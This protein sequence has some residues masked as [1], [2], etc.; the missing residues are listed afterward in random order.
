MNE[1]LLKRSEVPVELTWDLTD[2]Y[3]DNAE[4][5]ERMDWI[6]AE[7]KRFAE[8]WQGKLNTAE[9]IVQAMEQYR[10]VYEEMTLAGNYAELA[11]VVDYTDGELQATVGK[12][13]R[14][15]ADSASRLSF[16]DSELAQ[17]EES[18]L[19]VAMEQTTTAKHYLEEVIRRKPHLLHPEAERVLEA[20]APTAGMAFDIYNTAKLA[21]LQFSPFEVDG[22][23]YPL[24][25]AMFEDDY[26]YDENTA[27]R[28]AAFEAFSEQS[29]AYQNTI[30]TAYNGQIQ[31]E[32]TIA[33]L[34]GFDSVID[35]LLFEQ[36]VDRNLYERQIDIIMERLAPHMRRYAKLLQRVHKLDKITYADLKLPVDGNYTPKISIQQSRAYLEQGLSVMGEDYVTMIGEAYENRWVDFAQNIGKSTGGMCC[37]PYGSHSYIF[38][39]WMGR[40][41]DVFTLAHELGHAGHFKLCNAAQSVFDTDV[42]MCFVE[43]PSTMNELLLAHSMLK[44][45]DDKRFRRWVLSCMVGDTYYHNCVT[46]FLEAAYQRE[47]YRLVDAGHSVNAET[48]NRLMRETL[49]R[50]WGDTVELTDGAE[51][52]WMRQPHYYMGLYP[53]TYSVG[54]NIATQV[55]KRIEAEGATAVADWR[56]TLTAGSTTDTVGLAALAGVDLSTEAALLDTIDTIGGMI[57]EII[58]LTD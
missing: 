28:R 45:S 15:L 51:L 25:Y 39:N 16:V 7:S 47:V 4:L 19:K 58:A 17:Q 8:A 26:E 49:E 11:P 23:E 12:V 10:V 2:I 53:Y 18:I 5:F 27:V 31:H 37:S 14:V 50:F 21:D 34:R 54:L 6:T 35:Y 32:K 48:L 41:S 24:G 55:C 42:S 29:R 43:A 44:T 13:G 52:T 1:A 36:K 56:R 46:H 20:V 57:D 38:M 33:T 40:M 9:R 30:A 3:K 22:K